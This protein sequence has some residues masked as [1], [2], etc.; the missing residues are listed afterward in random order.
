MCQL[1]SDTP[2]TLPLFKNL[3]CSPKADTGLDEEPAESTDNKAETDI[4]KSKLT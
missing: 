2:V 3:Y 4:M 1:K